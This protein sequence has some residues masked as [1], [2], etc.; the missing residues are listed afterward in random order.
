MIVGKIY[1][2]KNLI[3]NEVYI[4]STIESLRVR[5]VK[6]LYEYRSWLSGKNKKLANRK[7]YESFY[8]YG[9]ECFRV[10]LI[11]IV[12][13]KTISELRKNAI[14]CTEFLIG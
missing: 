10:E 13:V 6:R 8:E 12:Q 3:T 1:R 11:S 2:I 7:L 5:N 14:E 4:G 9:L